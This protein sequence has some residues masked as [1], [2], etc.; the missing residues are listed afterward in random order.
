MN[1]SFRPAPWLAGRHLETIV[2]ALIPAS[3][4]PAPS[5]ARVVRVSPEAAVLVLVSRPDGEARG[6]LVLVHGI[7]GSAESGYM[8]R[9][10]SRALAYGWV[11]ARMNCRN[12]GGSEALSR[13]LYNAG[14]SDDVGRVLE[15][16]DAGGAPRPFAAVGFSLGGNLVLRYAGR[17]GSG[18]AADAVATVSPP[19]DLDACCRALERRENLLYHAHFTLS[20]CRILRR[21][22]RVRGLAGGK[23]E[24]RRIRTL[25]R[26]D[27]LYTA[28]DGG[29]ASAE[30]YYERASAGP[31]LEGVAVPALVLSAENDPFVPEEIFRGHRGAGAGRVRFEHPRRG[32]HL[33][34]WQSH[35]PR[36]WAA[37]A[38][39][40]FLAETLPTGRQRAGLELPRGFRLPA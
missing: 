21:I 12:C 37:E 27:A 30:D 34:F 17:A 22:H 6:T 7:G 20:L 26:L 25:R 10:A 2:P 19:V 3:P 24:F 23:P 28:P 14:Q 32:G 8:R 36:F 40:R 9:T 39:L 18:S 35:A 13:T 33:G 1:P 16:L 29:Y 11:V 4:V 31:D 5:S 38:V 15:D